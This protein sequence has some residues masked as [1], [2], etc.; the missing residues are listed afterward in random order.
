MGVCAP[1]CRHI[2]HFVADLTDIY[3]IAYL[4]WKVK[5]S[6]PDL[7]WQARTPNHVAYDVRPLMGLKY[8]RT[9]GLSDSSHVLFAAAAATFLCAISS[10]VTLILMIIL[11]FNKLTE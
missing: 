7:L 6:M 1:I 2:R 11:C 10:R 3:P 8:E 4:C 5:L 9:M